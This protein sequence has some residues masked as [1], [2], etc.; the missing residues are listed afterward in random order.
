VEAAV[1]DQPA[2]IDRVLASCIEERFRQAHIPP[3]VS[4]PGSLGR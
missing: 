3:F 2:Q 1:V 4:G